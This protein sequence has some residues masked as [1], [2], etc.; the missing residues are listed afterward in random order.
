M[1]ANQ[2]Q[3]KTKIKTLEKRVKGLTGTNA[4]LKNR[5]E[6]LEREF[7]FTKGLF[8]VAQTIILVLDPRGRI[9]LMNPYMERICGYRLEDVRGKDWF[10]TF[11]PKK[12]RAR[13][14]KLFLKAVGDIQTKGNINPI[15]A[16][17][18]REILIE[19]Y[20]KT[21]KD[22]KGNVTGL[23]SVG[24]DVTEREDLLNKVG[25]IAK[26][27]GWEMDLASGKAKWT[28]GTYDIV[29][30]KR[31][32]P[33]P[34]FKDHIN[35]Y[36]PEYRGMITKKM[37]DLVRIRKPIRFEAM[38]TTKKGNLK[39]CQAYGEAVVEGGKV[40]RLRGTFQDITDRKRYEEDLR[41][42]EARFMQLFKN[43]KSG[44]AVY[45][46]VNNGGNFVV[47][48]LNAAGCRLSKVRKSDVIGKRVTQAFSGVKAFGLFDVLKEVWK[49][50]KPKYHASREYRDEKLHAWFDNYVYKL[51]GGEIIAIYDDVTEVKKAEESLKKDRYYL[52]KAQELGSIGTWELDIEK[53]KLTW[54][55][56]SYRIFGIRPGTPLTYQV[57]LSRVHPDDREYVDAAWKA[58]LQKKQYNVEHRLL[59]DGK[60]K[61]VSQ[62]AELEYDEKGKAIRAIGFTQDISGRKIIEQM[63]DSLIRNVS[64][65]VKTPISNSLMA[66]EVIGNGLQ[67][68]NLDEIRKGQ[69]ILLEN[70]TQVRKDFDNILRVSFLGES[71]KIGIKREV[72]IAET[73]GSIID[74][75][76][77]TI[78]AKRL[79]FNIDIDKNADKVTIGPGEIRLLL[80]NLFENAL[81]FTEKGSI[82]IIARLKGKYVE[83]RVKDT[84]CGIDPGIIDRI[85]D[86]FFKRHPAVD[87]MGLG[88][89]ISKDLV[90]R[91]NGRISVESKG[92]GK[93]TTVVVTLPKK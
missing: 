13:I 70:I 25:D 88:L 4:K 54:T 27:G 64:H 24:Q 82:S 42:S 75:A 47:K 62:E 89:Y 32:G 37:N 53:N 77:V 60:I 6:I 28:K 74:A 38:L 49:T 78:G 69:S 41:E 85:F 71:P 84:G 50:G 15:I 65:S 83:I 43:M 56:E 80:S 57:F 63:K 17:N 33:I 8:D 90:N 59:I 61:W 22:S 7:D 21:L 34:G 44:V 16:K 92:T 12:D 35:W 26:I 39:W 11:L 79:K 52:K 40:V 23:L 48:D 30:I 72:S 1:T 31:G 20:D 2:K 46:A 3:L 36:L 9:V 87:G 18:G 86:K 5:N 14:K 93:G 55:E 76:K 19:W 81:K 73:V 51:P 67:R 45:D 91:W 68:N 66:C 29:E 10:N 58:A